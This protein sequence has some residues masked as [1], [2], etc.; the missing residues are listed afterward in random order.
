MPGIL[1]GEYAIDDFKKRIDDVLL[2]YGLIKAPHTTLEE[3]E[4]D[5]P[6]TLEEFEDEPTTLEEL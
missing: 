1:K 5:E 6:T 4:E 3:L 2:S